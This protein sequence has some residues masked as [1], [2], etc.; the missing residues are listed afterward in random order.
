MEHCTAVGLGFTAFVVV[1]HG[2]VVVVT[3]SL[4]RIQQNY[5]ILDKNYYGS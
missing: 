5:K 1:T 3:Q 4:P 2:A